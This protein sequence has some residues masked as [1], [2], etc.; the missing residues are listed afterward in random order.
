MYKPFL[1][2]RASLLAGLMA[3]SG[4]TAEPPT[5][6]SA[7]S[8]DEIRALREEMQRM[9][10]EYQQRLKAMEQRLK[11]LETQTKKP[12]APPEEKSPAP[13][14][15]SSA[16]ARHLA[17]AYQVAREEFLPTTE[18][19]YNRWWEVESPLR[20]RLDQVLEGYMDTTGSYFRAGYGVN[21]EGGIMQAFIAPG[22]LSK[23]RLGNESEQYG[24]LVLAR[25]WYKP[26]AFTSEEGRLPGSSETASLFAGPVVHTQ[27]RLA[28]TSDYE[29]K[30]QDFSLPE[31][32]A[33]IGN[34]FHGRPQTKFW[35]GAR[36]YRRYDIHINDFWFLNMSGLGGGV[37]DFDVG[38]GKLA[39]AFLGDSS[40]DATYATFYPPAPANPAGFAKRSLDLRL[41]DLPTGP[42]TSELVFVYARA[43]GG[44]DALGRSVEDADGFGFS[45]IHTAPDLLGEGSLNRLSLQVGTGPA[46]TFTAGFEKFTYNGGVFLLP[47]ERDSWRFRLTEHFTW[48]VNEHFSL[49]P[50]VVYQYTDYKNLGGTQHWFSGGVRP[51]LHFNRV[52]GLAF[53][54]GVDWVDDVGRNVSGH[55]AKV[56]LAPQVAMG[57][58]FMSRPVIRAFVTYAFWSD[59]FVGRI[60]G[61]D[62][63]TKDDG[64]LYGLQM[65]AWW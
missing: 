62:Y 28:Y 31:V 17:E 60:G 29:A 44:T 38:I 1:M 49:Q 6:G 10:R 33:S 64:W 12:S 54:G 21:N 16:Q 58:H 32:W 46:K 39:L 4:L 56:T 55:L 37:E 5:K 20:N 9:E 22:A 3:W 36:F 18:S 52:F 25:N 15:G 7:S 65:E 30:N 50:V 51:I 59:D 27:L 26:G 47:D 14:A 8:A 57:N 41:Y 19:A 23:Y 2:A 13:A 48:D 40:A 53:E 34:V 35:A 63:A 11:E 24:E 61:P 43:E 42:G 45:W